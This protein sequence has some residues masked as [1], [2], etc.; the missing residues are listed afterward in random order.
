MFTCSKSNYKEQPSK[1]HLL[2]DWTVSCKEN[3]D[4]FYLSNIKI[5]C[6]YKFKYLF[7]EILFYFN[8]FGSNET[9]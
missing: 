6:T 2:E 4:T 9:K 1:I 8:L 7:I 3:S 5:G